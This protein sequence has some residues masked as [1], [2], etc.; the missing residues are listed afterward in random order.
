MANEK[1]QCNQIC[2][3]NDSSDGCIKPNGRI[4]PMANSKPDAS[5][6]EQAKSQNKKQLIDAELLLEWVEKLEAYNMGRQSCLKKPKGIT[7]E[8]VRHMIG[9]MPKVDAEEVVRC[10]DCKHFISEICRH[11]F[12]MNLC[13]ADDFCSYGERRNDERTD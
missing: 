4:C 9:T 6:W 3:W 1:W 11:D 5:G 10:K 13:R 8:G 12:A 2:H 7:P